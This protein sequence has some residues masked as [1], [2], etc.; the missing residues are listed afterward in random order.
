LSGP[1]EDSLTRPFKPT[2]VVSSKV[3]LPPVVPVAVGPLTTNGG[4]HLGVGELSPLV[5]HERSL[6]R[7]LA[8]L[9][10]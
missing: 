4:S 10:E 1:V 8:R 7:I 5:S 2:T 6:D 3:D 9:V